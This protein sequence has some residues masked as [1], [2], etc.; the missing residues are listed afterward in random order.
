MKKYLYTLI[1]AMMTATNLMAQHAPMTF[2][3]VVFF[4]SDFPSAP[5]H[6]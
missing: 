2:V 6:P 3:I 1:A 5:Q 4:L